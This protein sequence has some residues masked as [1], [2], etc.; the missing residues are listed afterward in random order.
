MGRNKLVKGLILTGVITA[1]VLASGVNAFAG[2]WC[3]DYHGWW[4]DMGYSNYPSN[5]WSY[6]DGRWYFF[7]QSGYMETGWIKSDEDWFYCDNSG[8]MITGWQR[9]TGAWYYFDYDG[10]M[11]VDDWVDDY[12]LLASGKMAK[13]R[14]IDGVWL[15]SDGKM[16]EIQSSQPNTPTNDSQ[17]QTSGST[18]P[19]KETEAAE[20]VLPE[21]EP[22]TSSP[23]PQVPEISEGWDYTAGFTRYR[24]K[25][26]DYAKTCFIDLGRGQKY[27]FNEDTSMSVNSWIR[28][29]ADYYYASQS[30]HIVLGWQIIEGNKYYF[31]DPS[32]K[33]R[34]SNW[35]STDGS[36][37]YVGGDGRA[38]QNTEKELNGK[39]YYFDNEGRAVE[40]IKEK[41]NISISGQT[42]PE[43]IQQG[44]S[45]GL[46]GNIQSSYPLIWVKG[47]VVN[48]SGSEV[49]SK[50]V[51]PNSTYCN[52]RPEINNAIIFNYLEAGSYRYIIEAKDNNNFTKIL[53]DQPFTVYSPANNTSSNVAESGI[54]VVSDASNRITCKFG[55]YK[56]HKG[57]DIGWRNDESQNIVYAHSAG[58]VVQV[59]KGWTSSKGK[60]GMAS[61]GNYVT[62]QHSDK[63]WTRYA[64]LRSVN[65]S[66]GDSVNRGTAIG[67]MG[68]SGNVTGRHLHLELITNLRSNQRIDIEPYLNT[69]LP[70]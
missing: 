32:G 66:V 17:S 12:Y 43:N 8:A 60:S 46:H 5:Q 34:T 59:E 57:T 11:V 3:Q 42:L 24:L 67:V 9:I 31:D 58:T 26:G 37:Y 10:R 51:Y 69:E 65:V 19:E 7:N 27:Y 33:M 62:I 63:V 18:L 36:K 13:N 50:T 21:K 28:L 49:M 52:I 22:E 48:E 61:Y 68:E 1:A 47:S 45:F 20:P 70:N 6:I 25:N 53:I 64:H 54:R 40:V 35:V 55:G 4:Y 16:Q 44:K 39:I 14:E 41:S 38:M 23:D 29:G 15:G 2:Q 56:G 30:G